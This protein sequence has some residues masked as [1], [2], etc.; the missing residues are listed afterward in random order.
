[1]KKRVA[2]C[3]CGQVEVETT[4]EPIVTLAC[5]CDDCQEAARRMEA[6]PAA[7]PILDSHAGTPVML[8][9]RDRF[10]YAKGEDLLDDHKLDPKSITKRAVA[11][12][13][14]S[15]MMIRF[16]RGPHWVSV[17]RD[18]FD[19]DAPPVEMRIQTRFAPDAPDDGIPGHARYPMSL[20]GRL[21]G[22]RIAMVFGR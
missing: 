13:C 3:A 2:S 4:G 19:D 12:C 21:I 11:R 14:N 10:T 16:D 17:L 6:L 9:R 5:C 1:M 20:I 15:A 18:R 8:V 7:P 22:A